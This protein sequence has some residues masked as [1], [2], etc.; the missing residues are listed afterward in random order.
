MQNCFLIFLVFF[1]FFSYSEAE[2]RVATYIEPINNKFTELEYNSKNEIQN[3][4]DFVNK[5]SINPIKPKILN[6][7]ILE[8]IIKSLD[9]EYA[10]IDNLSSQEYIASINGKYSGFGFDLD[11]I[12][13]VPNGNYVITNVL[14]HS[15][16]FEKNLQIGDIIESVNGVRIYANK[17][18][19]EGALDMNVSNLNHEFVIIRNNN[20]MSVKLSPK[21]YTEAPISSKVLNKNIYYVKI[22]NCSQN[23]PLY[24][25]AE[26]DKFQKFKYEHLIIDLRHNLGGWEDSVIKVCAMMCDDNIIA[27]QKDKKGISEINRGDT[28]Q[29]TTVKPVVLISQNTASSAELLAACLRLR[30]GATLVGEKTYGKNKSQGIYEFGGRILKF[31]NAYISADDNFLLNFSGIEPDIVVVDQFESPYRDL[32]LQKAMEWLE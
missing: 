2:H 23:M 1:Q 8:A 14:E 11:V 21:E 27:Y 18:L 12:G 10:H 24:M 9:D 30:A 13:S 22:N 32:V 17:K 31:S 7:Y 29:I 15:A 4:L 20:K 6:E 26:L 16:A 25:E 3:L 5:N 19:Y 28:K